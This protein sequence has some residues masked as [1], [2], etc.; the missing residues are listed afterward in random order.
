MLI[1]DSSKMSVIEIVAQVT[2]VAFI[3]IGNL[4]VLIS[5]IRFARIRRSFSN[6][7]ITS[8]A[9]ADLMVGLVVIPLMMI[10]RQLSTLNQ[11]SDQVSVE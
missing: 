10:S 6:V 5:Y 2:L 3:T 1:T 9:F 4:L 7:Y 8:L 11:L